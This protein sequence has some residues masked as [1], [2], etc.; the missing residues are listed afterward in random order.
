[1]TSPKEAV[2]PSSVD[3]RSAFRVNDR[4]P[5]VNIEIHYKKKVIFC[6]KIDTKVLKI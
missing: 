2:H 1:M 4:Q 6:I 3:T 5:T